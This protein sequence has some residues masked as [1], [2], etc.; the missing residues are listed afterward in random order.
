MAI[1]VNPI[2]DFPLND[3]WVYASVV[4]SVLD[5][6]Y[7]KFSAISSANLGPQTYWG[8]LFCLPYGLSYTALRISTLSLALIGIITLY[9][10]TK[11]LSGN[12]KT[13]LLG[14]LVLAVNPL[15]FGLAN[16]FMT[17]VPFTSLTIIAFYFFAR[18]F[19]RVSSINIA[20]G[21]FFAFATILVR[22]V[23]I[24]VLLGFAFSYLIVNGFKLYN[25]VKAI[26]P[27]FL[28]LAI[29]FGYQHWLI[30]TGRMP[31]SS[32]HSSIQNL[33]TISSLAVWAWK[34]KLDIFNIMMYMGFFLTPIIWGFNFMKPSGVLMRE[35]LKIIQFAFAALGIALIVTILW[36]GMIMPISENILIKQGIGPLTLYDTYILNI[37]QPEISIATKI[38]W[39]IVSPISLVAAILI[40]Y[41]I[42]VITHNA[43]VGFLNPLT[44]SSTWPYWLFI[45]T[46]VAYFAILLV[47]GC[48]LTL[49]DRYLIFFIPLLTVLFSIDENQR[50]P[51]KK[52][53]GVI[54]SFILLIV[55]AGFS[56]AATHDY[57][58]W[59]RSRWIALHNLID[60][61]KVKVSQ[62]DGGYEF[63][64]LY[65]YDEKYKPKKKESWWWVIDNEYV[66]TSGPLDGYEEFKR[67]T[68]NRWLLLGESNIY[69]LRRNH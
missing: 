29:H 63:N 15:Y 12:T 42:T 43:I 6:G 10:L 54:C 1:L 38:F 23:G 5:T 3:D 62:I 26:L 7:Y 51:Q 41:H 33:T 59:N 17:D 39:Y 50:Q 52:N 53:Y 36:K 68:F 69:V 28:G 9:T 64:G 37:N 58:S 4:K 40:L 65:S 45:V 14:A 8:Y 18:G 35:R 31:S 11:E 24:V 19:K 13:A 67:Y 49:F 16:S 46:G 20:I 34:T 47:I 21:L 32:P 22:Q 57:L 44:R 2:G 66:I 55:Y 27:I 56:V 30:E 48:R 25:L 61:G 60:D